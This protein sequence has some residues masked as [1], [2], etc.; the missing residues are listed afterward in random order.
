MV[1][2]L[3]ARAVLSRRADWTKWFHCAWTPMSWLVSAQLPMRPVGV[4]V[5]C[6]ALL[7]LS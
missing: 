3:R 5:I 6:F 1:R 4:S 2:L 7:P